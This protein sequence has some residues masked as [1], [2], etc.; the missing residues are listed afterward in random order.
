[1]AELLRRQKEAPENEKEDYDEM[2]E[3]L[4]EEL[5]ADDQEEEHSSEYVEHLD[6]VGDD[7][8]ENEDKDSSAPE[9][10]FPEWMAKRGKKKEEDRP[11]LMIPKEM[12]E[13]YDALLEE[14][15]VGARTKKAGKAGHVWDKLEQEPAASGEPVMQAPK[16]WLEDGAGD[17]DGSGLGLFSGFGEEVAEALPRSRDGQGCIYCKEQYPDHED[18]ECILCPRTPELDMEKKKTGG[19]VET[20]EESEGGTDEGKGKEKEQTASATPLA[21]VAP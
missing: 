4:M 7:D 21:P 20:S 10:S 19:A 8:T 12:S 14:A 2:M 3:E 15:S 11:K 18:D 16:S 6:C 5:G 17:A 9:E 13:R 1:M